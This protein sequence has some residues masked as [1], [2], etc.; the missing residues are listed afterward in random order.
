MD[1]EAVARVM[2]CCYI[3]RHTV[4]GASVRGSRR[5]VSKTPEPASCGSQL[6]KPAR[7]P[8]DAKGGEAGKPEVW[9]RLG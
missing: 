1:R 8:F 3:W 9:Y 5:P 7:Q 4:L 2:G 6:K